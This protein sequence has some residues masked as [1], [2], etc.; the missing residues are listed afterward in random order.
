VMLPHAYHVPA[1]ILLVLGGVLAC[2]AGYRLFRI[3]LAI[4]GFIFGAMIAS[5][6]VG[7]SNNVGMVVAALVGGIAGALVLMFAYF[8]G[9]AIVGAGLGALV[10]HLGWQQFGTGDPPVLLIVAVSILGAAGAMLL[11]RYVI[12]VATAF[13]GAWTVVAGGLAVASGRGTRAVSDVWILYP[14]TPPPAQRWVPVAWVVIGVLGT[15][16]QL[17]VTGR[18][19]KST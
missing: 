19:K 1:A 10:A 4:Y 8:V 12:V 9:I 7:I 2:L 11:Q 16:V 14:L 5:S 17:G 13:A 15:A 18:K 6:V 3:V